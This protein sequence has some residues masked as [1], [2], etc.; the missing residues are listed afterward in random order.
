MAAAV[1]RQFSAAVELFR[2]WLTR[3]DSKLLPCLSNVAERALLEG[4]RF[5]LAVVA[6]PQGAG[7]RVTSDSA[8]YAEERASPTGRRRGPTVV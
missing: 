7:A 1:E 6:G 2:D 8:Y 4:D 3:H 5:C